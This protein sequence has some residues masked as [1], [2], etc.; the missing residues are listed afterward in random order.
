MSEDAPPA[1]PVQPLTRL[2]RGRHPGGIWVAPVYRDRGYA[3]ALEDV[4]IRAPL[5]P[6]LLEAARAAER[7]GHGLLLWDG[8]RSSEL[9]RTLYEQYRAHLQRS[10]GL[11][12]EPLADLVEQFVTHPD[13]ASSPPAHS[14]GGAVDV[15]LCDPR[16]GAPCD[17]GGEFDELTARSHPGFYDDA[18]DDAGRRY[19]AL[20]HQ[21]DDVMSHAGFVRFPAE[22]WHFEY[23]TA[24]WAG[25]MGR[26]IV[27]ERTAGPSPE[28]RANVRGLT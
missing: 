7:H 19:A 21:L 26:P 6:L 16:T 11:T 24:L 1:D 23:G 15:T 10:S 14:T 3:E 18:T 28:Q 8:W 12:A 4:W 17:L 5:L 25:A 9:Q 20:R 13:R 2:P 27:F 22:W